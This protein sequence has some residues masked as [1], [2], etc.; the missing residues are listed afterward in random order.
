MTDD[1]GGG[2]GAVDDGLGEDGRGGSGERRGPEERRAPCLRVPVEGGED[3]RQRLIDAGA[4]DRDLEP[5]VE[6]GALVLPLADPD[7]VPEDIA[8]DGDG[9]GEGAAGVE[10][11]EAVFAVREGPESAADRLGYDPTFDV[12]GRTALVRDEDD[13]EEVAEA[14]LASD[15]AVDS[16]YAVASPV[17]G[18]ERTRELRHVGGEAGT[19]AVH[20]EY[21]HEYAV[22]LEDV[23]FSPRLG[24]ER[25][26]VASQVEPDGGA[27][28]AGE[29][30]LDM[31]AGVGPFAV[32]M[33]ARGATVIACDVNP[34]AVRYLWDNAERQGVGDRVHPVLADARDV[35]EC[36]GRRDAPDGGPP[37]VD[38]VVM[39]LPH[40]ADAFLDAAMAAARDGCVVH[41]YDIRHEDDRFAGAEELVRAAAAEAGFD[42]EIRERR[43]VRSY[44]PHEV[45]VVLGVRLTA[46]E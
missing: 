15:E 13:P 16:V 22:D 38:R 11:G 18:R 21:G 10:R 36:L 37:G 30:V 24:T 42:V 26:R 45:N 33:A 2:D 1:D 29:R 17:E 6:D 28:G 25:D 12:V 32:P 31:F 41:Y 27:A 44:A 5:V 39:N 3:A 4:L 35:A 8:V 40:S 7:A 43:E 46:V 19:E 34:D 20:R 23:Y 14:L 9:N